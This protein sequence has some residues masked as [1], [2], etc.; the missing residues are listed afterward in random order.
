MYK[1]HLLLLLL[2]LSVSFHLFGQQ[3]FQSEELLPTSLT[4]EV[5]TSQKTVFT[6]H[7]LA[8]KVEPDQKYD[9]LIEGQKVS[10]P[11]PTRSQ[12]QSL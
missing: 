4:N 5:Q 10:Q 11:S 9:V 12:T 2:T 7:L 8:D 3:Y 1:I 6:D